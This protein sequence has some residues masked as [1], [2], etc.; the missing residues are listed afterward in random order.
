MS[1]ITPI[2]LAGGTGKRLWPASSESCPK[3]FCNL[4]DTELTLFQETVLRYSSDDQFEYNSPIIVTNLKYTNFV[5]EQLK[6]IDKEAECI[7]CE[8]EPKNTAASILAG[9]EYMLK[10]G[11]EHE[12]VIVVPSDQYFED[13]AYIN[14]VFQESAK[15]SGEH[16]ITI[17]GVKPTRA[18]N[19]YG[20][21]VPSRHDDKP[22]LV[23][24][25]IEKP[26]QERAIELFA[27]KKSLWN[28]GIFLFTSSKIKDRYMKLSSELAKSVCA[29]MDKANI[30]N[31]VIH[32]DPST[33]SACNKVSIDYEIIERS[34][35]I[36]VIPLETNWSDLGTWDSIW[37]TFNNNGNLVD[38]N[39]NSFEC[40]GS[41]FR[42]YLTTK[43]VGIGLKDT[44]VVQTDKLTLVMD[45]SLSPELDKIVSS[46]PHD[47]SDDS[48]GQRHFRPW[49]FFENLQESKSHKVKS[50]H[51]SPHSRISLQ[52]H[53]ERTEHWIIVKGQANIEI[54]GEK[55]V[56]SEGHSIDIPKRSVH[57]IENS[58]DD[59]LEII[60]VQKGEYLEEDDIIRIEDDYDRVSKK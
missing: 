46:I 29:S 14:K 7:I 36:F 21:I 26:N 4:Q 28:C 35:D 16:T 1:N 32:L 27:A 53:N 44:V 57:R 58:Q 39:S 48:V 56:L 22:C 33:W 24:K 5:K 2:I 52:Y 60:E 20:Y 18:S 49:G 11:K 59:Y 3:Q 19:S 42:N 47:I 55:F 38:N 40:E 23:E 37:S 10:N 30:H 50:L 43:L 15:Y 8:P 25:F 17:F 9:A 6:E 12:P 34:D 45:K 31:H 51:I 54:D 13:D 41:L